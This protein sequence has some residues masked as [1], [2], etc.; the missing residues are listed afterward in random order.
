MFLT[1]SRT[2]L[3]RVE[4]TLLPISGK[5]V[6]FPTTCNDDSASVSTAMAE[7]GSDIG[8]TEEGEVEDDH[9]GVVWSEPVA[10]S[11]SLSRYYWIAIEPSTGTGILK[12]SNAYRPLLPRLSPLRI[13]SFLSSFRTSWSRPSSS[14]TL[15]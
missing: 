14:Q 9:Q 12:R 7:V 4:N 3:R 5:S 2:H 8:S 1:R 11:K 6:P 10:R 13:P 15:V